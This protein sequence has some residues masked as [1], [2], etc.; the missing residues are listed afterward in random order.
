MF[1]HNYYMSTM[2]QQIDYYKLDYEHKLL[3]VRSVFDEAKNT[4]PVYQKLSVLL[5]GKRTIQEKYLDQLYEQVQQVINKFES[6]EAIE[7]MGTL[8]V[9]LAR[10][11]ELEEQ[12][13]EQESKELTRMEQA[14]FRIEDDRP[15]PL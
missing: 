4:H 3:Y 9:K 13:R 11:K 2:A 14:M 6:G 15:N 8:A 10:I 5:S 1:V 7:K 12:D